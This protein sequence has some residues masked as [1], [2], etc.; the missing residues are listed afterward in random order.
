MTE[1]TTEEERGNVGTTETKK[2]EPI[3]PGFR[4]YSDGIPKIGDD[5][6]GIL[7]DVNEKY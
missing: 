1:N 7:S 3:E 6:D 5:Y 4:T 2:E